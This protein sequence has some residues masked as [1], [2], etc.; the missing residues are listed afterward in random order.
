MIHKWK[1]PRTIQVQTTGVE[2]EQAELQWMVL[3]GYAQNPDQLANA[4]EPIA[5]KDTV[6]IPEAMSKF[7]RKGYEGEVVNSWMTSRH[8]EDEIEDQQSYLNSVYEKLL[9]DNDRPTVLLAFSQGAATA[10]R[11]LDNNEVKLSACAIYAGWPPDDVDYEKAYWKKL[12]HYY[13]LGDNDYFIKGDRI[14]ELRKKE[15]FQKLNPEW[16]D[17]IGPHEVL[18]QVLESLR[19]RL[20]RDFLA[21]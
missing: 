15:Y 11:W 4:F 5:R 17:F 18:G 19:N 21:S 7:Y 13:L 20:V 10:L 2:I 3:H 9:K 16:I 1:V 14:E 12:K 8:R 6:I